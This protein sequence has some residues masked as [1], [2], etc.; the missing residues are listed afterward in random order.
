MLS[1]KV[2]SGPSAAALLVV[3]VVAAFGARPAWAQE[4]SSISEPERGQAAGA[5]GSRPGPLH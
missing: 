4:A 5:A 3:G 2:V 1:I